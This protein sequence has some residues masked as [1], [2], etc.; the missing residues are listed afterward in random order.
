MSSQ[1][2][3][4]HTVHYSVLGLGHSGERL[5]L[6]EGFRGRSEA[7]A[8][9]RLIARELGLPLPATSSD[10]DEAD[11]YNALAADPVPLENGARANDN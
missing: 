1:R 4:K 5:R 8:G 6:G 2:A 11:G 10:D 9:V 3:G 7:R